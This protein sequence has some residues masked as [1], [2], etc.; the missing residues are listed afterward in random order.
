MKRL[1]GAA[2][3]FG[4]GRWA[5]RGAAFSRA[6][7]RATAANLREVG[8]NV[9]LAPVLDVARP[10]GDDRR[11]R[12][13]LRLDRRRG[14]SYR[15][16]LRRRPAGRWRRRHGQ[17]LSPASA[18]PTE[19]TDF[20]VQRIDLS[21]RDAARRRRG[22]LPAL[23]RR[24]GRDG[25]AEHGDLPGLLAASRRPSPGRSRP[26]S[27]AAASASTASRSPTR[28]KRSRCA[29][30]AGPPRPAWRRRRP[31]PICSSSPTTGPPRRPGA[32]CCA[33]CAPRPRLAPRSRPRSAGSCA[34]ATAWRLARFGD[35]DLHF[36]GLRLRRSS[37][38]KICTR[39]RPEPFAAY[40]A[41]SASAEHRFVAE[42]LAAAEGGDADAGGDRRHVLLGAH[43]LADRRGDLAADLF[44]PR[45]GSQRGRTIANSSP[46]SRASTSVSRA[47]PRSTAAISASTRSPAGWPSVSLT[48]LKW[49]RSSISSAPG[50]PVAV[51]AGQLGP[52][53]LL[54]AAPVLQ[55]GERV[56]AGL[57]RP[58]PASVRCGSRPAPAPPAAPPA[59]GRRGRSSPAGRR[60]GGS[61]RARPAARCGRRSG[62]VRRRL[63]HGAGRARRSACRA[64]PARRRPRRAGPSVAAGGQVGDVEGAGGEADQGGAALGTV[65]GRSA[66]AVDGAEDVDP[67]AADRQPHRRRRRRACRG[68]ALAAGRRRAGCRSR[69]RSRAAACTVRPLAAGVDQ[70]EVVAA[71]AR[72]RRRLPSG[73]R[74]RIG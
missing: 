30:S 55:P 38:S 16:A 48:C 59:R 28:S 17:A 73:P 4:A 9:D 65:S 67:G 13:G 64:R 69:R 26:A 3:R 5:P 25:D 66:V 6:Q 32:P 19:N 40:S 34:C 68:R 74:S 63:R 14:G 50:D 51:A 54:E 1:G 72:A 61:D 36:A 23:H 44:V 47:R 11:H 37:A 15:R 33:G 20:A 7:G 43:A 53:V 31:A 70:R 46:P 29:T 58:V 45:R 41:A 39:S 60:R 8:V 49:S 22:A 35:G 24:R 12:P 52:Q 18:R 42:P 57:Q 62:S 71:P 27:C 2:E 21:K 56:L 10:G